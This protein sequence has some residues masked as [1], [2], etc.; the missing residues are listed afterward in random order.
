[1]RGLPHVRLACHICRISAMRSPS[2]EGLPSRARD[3]QRQK[4]RKPRRCQAMTVWG[5]KRTRACGSSIACAR[6]PTPE[7]AKAKAMPSDDGLGLE[8]DQGVWPLWP[9]APQAHP[10]E[11]VGGAEFRF[12]RL[13][14]EDCQLMSERQVFKHEPGL[15]SKAGEQRA[16]E[17]KNDIEHGEVNFGGLCRHI[18]VFKGARGFR[19]PHHP[20]QPVFAP[21]SRLVRRSVEQRN[22][23]PEG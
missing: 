12:V 13:S 17:R 1:M 3:F 23:V 21:Q 11:S 8:E 18:K 6:F 9:E 16:Q 2:R 14:F 22:L 10:Q 7:E 15:R 20:E 19:Y 5:W 4:R